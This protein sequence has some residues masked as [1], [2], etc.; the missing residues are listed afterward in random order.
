MPTSFHLDMAD[1]M[2][3]RSVARDPDGFLP[4][5]FGDYPDPAGLMLVR[6]LTKLSA[7]VASAR[8][9][10]RRPAAMPEHEEAACA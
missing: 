4:E 10:L 6:G 8:D 7:V 2:A 1:T 3:R 9:L 5:Q